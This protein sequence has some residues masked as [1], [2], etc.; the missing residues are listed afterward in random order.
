M[1]NIELR[2]AILVGEGAL[3]EGWRRAHYRGSEHAHAERRWDGAD[4][5]QPAWV[6]RRCWAQVKHDG[7]L[8]MRGDDGPSQLHMVSGRAADATAAL[9]VAE[10]L[11]ALWMAAP[12]GSPWACPDSLQLETP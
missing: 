2:L 5:A 4:T 3:P 10:E 1:N 12:V 6:Q 7:W 8:W 9:Q 11:A